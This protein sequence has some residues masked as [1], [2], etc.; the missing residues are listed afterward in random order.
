MKNL[1]IDLGNTLLKLFIFENG[2]VINSSIANDYKN[3]LKQIESAIKI[4]S[5]KKAI[6]SS[7]RS[8]DVS[9]L[10]VLDKKVKRIIKMSP[11]LEFPINIHYKT[12]S[13]LGQDRLAAVCGASVFWP[14]KNILVIDSGTAITYD[15]LIDGKEYLGG[16]I[17]PGI[18]T[19]FKSLHTFTGKLPL[20]S[21]NKDLNADYGTTTD[22]AIILG[23]QNGIFHE[24]NGIIREF[25]SK[26]H[27]L[28]VVFTGGDSFFFEKLIKNRIFA[29]PNLTAFGLNKILEIND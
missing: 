3:L 1:V 26:Y 7:V 23:V 22:E 17:S 9:I 8:D 2:A 12:K 16:T 15:I 28:G 27:D 5:P 11:N 10:S 19:R 6:I 25:S 13:T 20:L 21:I 18:S 14:G 29:E 24:V 4:H